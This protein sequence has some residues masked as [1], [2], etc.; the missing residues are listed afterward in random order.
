MEKRSKRM[1]KFW[2]AK[3]ESEEALVPYIWLVKQFPISDR[4]RLEN[5][6]IR[7]ISLSAKFLR[8]KGFVKRFRVDLWRGISWALAQSREMG[9]AAPLQYWKELGPVLRAQLPEEKRGSKNQMRRCR[10]FYLKS[11]I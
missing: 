2:M 9:V 10:R 5:C 6:L 3:L 1:E 11:K 8:K 4:F 7:V